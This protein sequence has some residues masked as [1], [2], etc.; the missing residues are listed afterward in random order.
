MLAITANRLDDGRV[1]YRTPLGAWSA[2]LS[3]AEL[4]E[5]AAAAEDVLKLALSEEGVVVDPYTMDVEAGVPGGK[6]RIR[7][8]IRNTGPSASTVL[9]LN[10]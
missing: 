10:A 1:V 3:E 7:E 5:T 9:E 2:H 4:F 8:T 6:K